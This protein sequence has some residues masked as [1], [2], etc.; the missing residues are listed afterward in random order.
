MAIE[1]RATSGN[2]AL[3]TNADDPSVIV[4]R[5]DRLG[6]TPN[7][8]RCP[9]LIYPGAVPITGP[10][11][12]VAFET[13][14]DANQWPS[15]WRNGIFPFHHFHSTAHEVLGVY[16]GTATALLGGEQGI[17]VNV[18]A[19]DVVVIPAG[20]AHMRLAANDLGIVGAYPRGQHPDLCRSP[21][22]DPDRAARA[23]AA[24]TIPARDPVHGSGGPL[25]ANW[26]A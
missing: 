13:L 9:V 25:L 3:I 2:A 1:T 26:Q 16:A 24:V 17:T 6:A 11:P 22:A 23:V 15:A 10:D 21:V 12:A 7:N 19:G 20:V 4:H 5:L 18:T 8:P 14:F